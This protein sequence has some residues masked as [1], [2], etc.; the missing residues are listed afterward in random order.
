MNVKVYIGLLLGLF[1]GALLCLMGVML[2]W[3][4]NWFPENPPSAR[5]LPLPFFLLF[6]SGWALSSWLFVRGAQNIPT[7]C[8]RGF[9][10]GA[11]EW[12][13]MIFVGIIYAN[14]DSIDA[15]TS[16]GSDHALAAAAISGVVVSIGIG[17]FSFFMAQICLACFAF[18]YFWG[19]QVKK[20]SQGKPCPMCA[21]VIPAKARLCH[22]CG[23][24][25]VKQPE[26]QPNQ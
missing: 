8:S 2:F 9:L 14:K 11:A 15:V 5:E 22:F 17:A 13:G 18:S 21:E 20:E 12:L 7:V 3:D 6:V 26:Y 1:S 25:L 19:R 10:F 23:A 24:F 16:I 4:L